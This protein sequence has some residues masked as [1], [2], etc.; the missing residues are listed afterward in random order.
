MSMVPDI[1]AGTGTEFEETPVRGG[2]GGCRSRKDRRST[3]EILVRTAPGHFPI[4]RFH[5]QCPSFR[6]VRDT[7]GALNGA[8]VNTGRPGRTYSPDAFSGQFP[9]CPTIRP[10]C[11][12]TS[13]GPPPGL[14]LQRSLHVPTLRRKGNFRGRPAV[15]LSGGES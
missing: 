8:P 9:I 14:K 10:E 7:T 11:E 3:V 6:A 13:A 1:T 4:S 12:R 5:A 2:S 15:Y